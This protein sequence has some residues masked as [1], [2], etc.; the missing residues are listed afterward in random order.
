VRSNHDDFVDRWIINADWKKNVKNSVEYM[1]YAKILLED[2][3]K[4]G[5]IPY[6]LNQKFSDVKTLGRID[7]FTV[8][9]WELAVHGDYGQNGS[10][11]SITQFR[12]LNTKLVTAHSHT[13]GRKD[14]ALTVGTSTKKRL[15]Y[16]LGASSWL[17]SH[18]I[19]HK[20]GKA[21]HI[22]FMDG[23]YTTFNKSNQI[24]PLNKK[25]RIILTGTTK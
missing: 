22:N 10:K 25:G 15:G 18:V 4:D 24:E 21:Q 7:T 20:D 9:K 6:I 12:K 3:A 1:E 13:P 2:K 8:K 11:G 19:I 23:E 16:N 14:G 17:N 5:I